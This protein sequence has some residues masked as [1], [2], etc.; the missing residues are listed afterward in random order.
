MNGSQQ[1][2]DRI[3]LE[4]VQSLTA[5]LDLPGLLSTILQQLAK[6]VSFDSASIMLLEGDQLE[7][8]ARLSTFPTDKAP[9]K[10]KVIE[11]A[12]IAE[13]IAQR[14]P[15]RIDDTTSDR[16]WRKREGNELIRS[17]L[18][19]PLV[20]DG[21]VIGLLNI[22]H[23][24]PGHFDSQSE[25]TASVFAAFAAVALH[26]A[27]LH[28]RLQN[29]LAE[30][31]HTEAELQE[32]RARLAVRVAE[33]I[34]ALRAVNQEM[35]RTSRMKDEF[36]A[37]M[38]HELRTPL[39]V[40][41]SMTD[42]LREEVYG[43]INDRQLQALERIDRQSKQLLSLI[44]D[45]LD[46]ARIESGRLELLAQQIDVEAICRACVAQVDF[47]AKQQ[48]FSLSIQPSLPKMIADERRL[49]QILTNLLSNA[50][51]FTA[52]GGRLGL[53]VMQDDE[54]NCLALTVWDTGI[55]IDE[56]DL[57]RLFHPFVQLDGALSRQYEGTGLGLTLIHRLT[58]L[59]GGSLT[60]ESSK[61]EGSRFIVRIPFVAVLDHDIAKRTSIAK[62]DAPTVLLVAGLEHADAL[63]ISDLRSTGFYVEITLQDAELQI[64][65]APDLVIVI[66][67]PPLRHIVRTVKTLRANTL[68][69]DRPLIV[70]TTLQLPGYSEAILAAGATEYLVK[71]IGKQAFEQLIKTHIS[72]F[73]TNFKHSQGEK[74]T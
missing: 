38:S 49:R 52:K 48:H 31:A 39:N 19:V 58:A 1:N 72:F 17:W 66:G 30:R 9:L 2:L 24:A 65:E 47:S 6:L 29:E 64:D 74:N 67:Y 3:L 27:A 51:K 73:H 57:R 16:R 18:G 40:I 54:R 7:L 14:H 53:E 36:L 63:L 70:L 46:V 5:E 41:I 43:A 62:P 25:Q 68:L 20:A 50:V 4:V 60:I 69:A 13:A 21:L 33:Q 11:L 35:A 28:S 44:S 56:N 45:V 61:G 12:H 22:S 8:T 34:A 42:L 26:N 37:A 71:P 55:G 15:V 23:S 10:L 59:H 32:E